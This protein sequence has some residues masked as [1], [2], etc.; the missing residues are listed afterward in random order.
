M[1]SQAEVP[2]PPAQRPLPDRPWVAAA[3][4]GVV[5]LCVLLPSQPWAK[6]IGHPVSDLSDHLQGMWWFGGEILEGRWPLLSDQ[7]HFPNATPLWFVDPVGGLMALCLRWMGPVLSYNA[8]LAVQLWL[9][10]VA[11][12]AMARSLGASGRGALVAG[13]FLCTSPFLLGLVHSGLTEGLGLASVVLFT[14]ALLR[15][16][17]RVGDG[18]KP[19]WR[20]GLLAGV[21][22]MWVGLQ[23]PIYLVGSLVL[24]A[25]AA[26]GTLAQLPRRLGVLAIILGVAHAPLLILR[27]V[28]KATLGLKDTVAGSLAPGWQPAG[29][30]VVDLVGFVHPGPYYF[31]DTPA[32]G[33][34]GVLQIHYLGLIALGLAALGWRHRHS[35]RGPI[36]WVGV[37]CMG[38]SLC[39]Y[40]RHIPSLQAPLRLPAWLLWLDGSPVDF[41]HHP[42]RLVAVLLPLLAVLIAAGVD[43]LGP[44]MAAGLGTLMVLE[45]LL[46]SPLPWPIASTD[47]TPPGVYAALPPG[48]VM[49]WPPDGTDWN[50]RYLRWQTVHGQ[51]IAY[52]VNTTFPEAARHDPLLWEL[53]FDLSDPGDRLRNRDIQVRPPQKSSQP[54]TISEQGFRSIVFHGEAVNEGSRQRTLKALTLAHGPPHAIEGQTYAWTLD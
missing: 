11:G 2:V 45:A 48:P 14:W 21:L 53:F 42:Y 7:T 16:M 29:V 5:V 50:R 12:W 4:F 3:V 30:P 37:L 43:R 27:G 39:L 10:G 51:A 23:S 25:G 52:G 17:G 33:N 18:A 13:A 40:Q 49:D 34:P 8:V 24:C 36:V 54:R 20:A 1:V 28:I 22:L 15:A 19:S 35:V 41:I 38:P 44:R 6:A 9:A 46:V 31:P 32:L 47:T 26:I